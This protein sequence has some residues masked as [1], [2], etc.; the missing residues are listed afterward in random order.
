MH[1]LG[2]SAAA[3]LG[4]RTGRHPDCRANLSLTTSLRSGDKGVIGDDITDGSGREQAVRHLVIV[5]AEPFLTAQE[6]A[7]NN[8][9]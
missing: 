5:P 9:A 3:Q 8:A 7:G 6:Y 1:C 2:G 4:Q